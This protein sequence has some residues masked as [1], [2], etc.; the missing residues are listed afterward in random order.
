[1]NSSP[2][3]T[4]SERTEPT[5]LDSVLVLLVHT[6][7]RAGIRGDFDDRAQARSLLQRYFVQRHQRHLH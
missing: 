7:I 2:A 5:S 1:M 6:Y 3:H 4:S